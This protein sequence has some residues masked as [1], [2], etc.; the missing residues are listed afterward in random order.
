[1][2][3]G[4]LNGS[5]FRDKPI[6]YAPPKPTPDRA[7]SEVLAAAREKI[8]AQVLGGHAYRDGDDGTRVHRRCGKVEKSPG[9]VART[10][11]V[12]GSTK[13]IHSN[14]ATRVCTPAELNKM[15]ARSKNPLDPASLRGKTLVG[16]GAA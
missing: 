6:G 14:Y 11:R 9:Q 1:M 4:R 16:D 7:P 15:F 12:R 10:T 8:D 3:R 13:R 2:A 5:V